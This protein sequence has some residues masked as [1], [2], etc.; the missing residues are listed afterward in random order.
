MF[1]ATLAQFVQTPW[2]KTIADY[3][4]WGTPFQSAVYALL[5]LFLRIFT[6]RLHLK[7]RISLII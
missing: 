4:Q 6:L 3:F 5:I 1:P 2:I 7:F